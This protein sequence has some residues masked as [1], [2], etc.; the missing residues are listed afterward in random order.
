MQ[1]LITIATIIG[2]SLLAI[3]CEQHTG[4]WERDLSLAGSVSFYFGPYYIKEATCTYDGEVPGELHYLKSTV[5]TQKVS[6]TEVSL[7][8]VAQ[9]GAAT[10]K[11]SIPVMALSGEPYNVTFDYTSEDATVVYIDGT[12]APVSDSAT[13]T[14]AGWIKEPVML[15][16]STGSAAGNLD[17]SSDSD[18]AIPEY[19]CDINIGST[20]NGVPLNIRITDI[21]H[22]NDY[23]D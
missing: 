12:A 6:D 20:L 18:P 9:W 7:S 22:Y 16:T 11:V 5:Y 1:K 14:I 2:G 10:F 23:N 15:R 4:G 17:S 8:C 13:A 21:S 3:S 19:T